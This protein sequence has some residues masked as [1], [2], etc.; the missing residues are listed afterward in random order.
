MLLG[1]G[2]RSREHRLSHCDSALSSQRLSGVLDV[3]QLFVLAELEFSNQAGD[4]DLQGHWRDLGFPS[5][6]A[7]AT[8]RLYWRLPLC[9]FSAI[10]NGTDTAMRY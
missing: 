4:L 3:A 7:P 2:R 6:A 10:A 8:A 9:Q 5:V 1:F